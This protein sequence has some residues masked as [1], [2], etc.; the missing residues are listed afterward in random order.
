MSLTLNDIVIESRDSDKYVNGTQLCNAGGKKF[1]NWF[2]LDSTKDLINTLETRLWVGS[3]MKRHVVDIVS[4]GRNELRGSWV[5]PDLAIQLAQWISSTFALE[6]SSWIRQLF[7]TGSVSLIPHQPDELIR[8]Q[9][10]VERQARELKERD[11]KIMERDEK[12]MERDARIN[13][14]NT[15][16]KELITYKK[17]MTKD[18]R[19]YIVSTAEYARQGIFKIGRTRNDMK[20]RS[21][22]HNTSHIKGDKVKVLK[23]FMVADSVAIEKNVHTKLKGLLLDGEREFFL[24]PYYLL[25]RIV[26]LIVNHDD[27]EHDVVNKT[28]DMVYELKQSAFN[29]SEWTRGLSDDIFEENIMTITC[30]GTSPVKMDVSAW[31]DEQKK[32]FVS[33]CLDEYIR[34]E[35][36]TNDE[37]YR[38]VWKAFRDYLRS[39]LSMSVARF[40]PSDW[41]GYV[42][43]EAERGSAVICWKSG[44]N[45]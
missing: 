32:E 6:V 38:V 16:H 11:A 25:E 45:V 14:L 34:I 33:N 27:D 35:N 29:S 26:D 7:T 19:I 13:R 15:I 28:I 42:K 3:L 44:S 18:E 12:L 40:R 9:N 8:L 20:R 31:S 37:D 1:S 2:R 4:T 30:P 17:K 36:S 21:S 22:G 43:A 10:E 5:H 41:R 24:C 23:E 39:Q